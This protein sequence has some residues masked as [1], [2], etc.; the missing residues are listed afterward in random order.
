MNSR[1]FR[2]QD[3][4]AGMVLSA[5]VV[6]DN[7]RVILT[8]NTVLTEKMIDRLQNW[9]IFVVDV[10]DEVAVQQPDRPDMP[11]YPLPAV[12][13][14]Q[15]KFVAAYLDI[16]TEVKDTFE[17]IRYY[18]KVPLDHL[19]VLANTSVRQMTQI[20]G[21]MNYLRLLDTMDDR[22]VQHSVNVAII[23][24]V[25]GRWLGSSHRQIGEMILAGLLHDVGKMLIDPEIAVKR[26]WELSAEEIAVY[27]S[28]SVQG[29]RL[30]NNKVYHLP[31]NVMAGVLQHHEWN[32]GSGS[33]LALAGEKIHYY[34]K[35][36]SVADLYELMTSEGLKAD[37]V[38]PWQ[39]VEILVSQ[40]FKRLDPE[41]AGIFLSHLRE[42]LLGNPVRLSDGREAVVVYLGTDIFQRP[43]VRTRDGKFI[44]LE[45]ERNIR[46]REML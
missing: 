11:F 25:L 38:T 37:P 27:Q 7:G 43:V 24:G 14:E 16:V 21:A 19:A 1:R 12:S 18:K 44:D 35:I 42:Q 10:Q 5:P 33:P 31:F 8:Q 2:I 34:A 20:P 29:Y 6:G 36:I 30:L 22:I 40:M 46:I 26:I 9:N 23:A 13:D 32:D 4:E 41:V 3:A 39:A 28:H 15:R 17:K 45:K